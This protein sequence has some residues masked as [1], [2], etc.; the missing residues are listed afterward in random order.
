MD[1]TNEASLNGEDDDGEKDIATS[2]MMNR[3]SDEESLVLRLKESIVERSRVRHK[4]DRISLEHE[5]TQKKAKLESI[6]ASMNEK[7]KFRK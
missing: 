1:L 3:K 2:Y 5:W 6:K 4:N 7:F